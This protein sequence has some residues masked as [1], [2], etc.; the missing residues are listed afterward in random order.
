MRMGLPYILR[1]L[2]LDLQEN[3]L[4]NERNVHSYKPGKFMLSA[5]Q[6]IDLRAAESKE[7]YWTN[8]YFNNPGKG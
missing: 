3:A 6:V 8:Y 5:G 7:I 2:N 1:D 4:Q